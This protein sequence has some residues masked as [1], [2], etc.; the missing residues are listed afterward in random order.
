[1]GYV[2]LKTPKSVSRCELNFVIV[3]SFLKVDYLSEA[4]TQH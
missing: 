4:L 2:K 1:M 3:E